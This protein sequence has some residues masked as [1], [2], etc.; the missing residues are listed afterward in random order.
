MS[1]PRNVVLVRKDIKVDGEHAPM[2]HTWLLFRAFLAIGLV[3]R[4]SLLRMTLPRTRR[5]PPRIQPVD[6][7]TDDLLIRISERDLLLLGLLERAVESAG[8][9][10]RVVAISGPCAR[11]TL[12]R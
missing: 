10:G 6:D 11:E 12:S 8:E 3:R 9:V 5:Q 4:A 2:E 7:R 1:K